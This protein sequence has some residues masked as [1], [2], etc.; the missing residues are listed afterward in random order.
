MRLFIVP[1]IVMILAQATKLISEA[2]RGNFS[3]EHFN[4]YGG[5]PSAHGALASSLVTILYLEQGLGDAALAV[6]VILFFI[7]VR[8]ATGFRR[9]LG[10]HAELINLMIKDLG[11]AKEYKYPVLNQRLGHTPTQ[12]LA[13]TIFG[14]VVTYIITLALPYF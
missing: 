11:K 5:M 10:L 14:V 13:G 8:D 9:Q 4:N 1:L 12:V 2:L 7:V 3:W 6:A